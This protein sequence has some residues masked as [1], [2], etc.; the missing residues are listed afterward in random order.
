MIVDM[1]VTILFT[2][3]LVKEVGQ[4]QESIDLLNRKLSEGEMSHQVRRVGGF[5]YH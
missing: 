4:I 2:P 5:Q 1:L 3:R